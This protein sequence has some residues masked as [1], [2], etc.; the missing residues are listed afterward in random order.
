MKFTVAIAGK[1]NVGK[2]SLFNKLNRRRLAIVD[3]QPGVTRD[4]KE[5][6]VDLLGHEITL[7]DT[8]GWDD[9]PTSLESKILAHTTTVL[10]SANL[11]LF[12]VDARGGIT[13]EDLL[14]VEAARKANRP[15]ILVANK[16]ESKRYIDL[17]E[18][19]KF[20]F[21]EPIYCSSAHGVGIAD[22]IEEILRYKIEYDKQMLETPPVDEEILK[23]SIIGRPNVGKSTLFNAILGFERTITSEIPGTTRDSINY[24]L[25]K[26]DKAIE[27]ID[28]AGLRK[29]AN[30]DEKIEELSVAESIN[31]IRRS[32]IS[33]LVI[34][35]E[36]PLEKQ[37]LAIARVAIQEGK[38]LILVVNKCDLIKRKKAFEQEML[39]LIEENLS[40]VTGLPVVY[41]SAIFKENIEDI[42]VQAAEIEKR[43]RKK[44]STSKLNEWLK[45]ATEQYIAPLAKNGRRIR[46]KYITQT[47]I[48]PPNF[49]FFC[50]IPED[51]PD[52]YMRYL[53]NSL[54]KTF[55]LMGIPI[56]MNLT[57]NKNPYDKKKK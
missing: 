30:I 21:G 53:R 45:M 36:N 18:L 29:K 19:Y 25:T 12:I 31:A 27:L 20:G 48:R 34:S 55:N 15:I 40:E 44:I 17:N 14:F 6:S 23:V 42:F 5:S 3:D 11:I 13:A 38:P 52:S 24:F 37:D 39:H 46:F 54:R 51:L 28:T 50:N 43:W 10:E 22:L 26:A 9:S 33:L 8:A 57:K 7:I 4:S 35:A 56:R 1:P 32:N 49:N 47:N 2:S 16:A 41:I